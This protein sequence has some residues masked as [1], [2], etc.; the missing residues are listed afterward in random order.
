MRD[1]HYFV[2][3]YLAFPRVYVRQLRLRIHEYFAQNGRN[4]ALLIEI[5]KGSYTLEFRDAIPVMSPRYSPALVRQTERA[6]ARL[7]PVMKL[8]FWIAVAAAVV[9]AVGWYR[10]GRTVARP[11]VP[12]PLDAVIQPDRQTRVVVSDS[13]LMLR[14]LGQHEITLN[15]YL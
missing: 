2:T 9:C 3:V 1:G 13:S 11:Q 14:L 4:E 8:L 7:N 15:D 12:W 6:R 5:P 10:A